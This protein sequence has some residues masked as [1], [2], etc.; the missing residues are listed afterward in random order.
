MK[1]LI[2][3][4]PKF[5]GYHLIE[6]ALTSGHQVTTFNRGQTSPE[7]FPEIEKLAG[8]R[9]GSLE[10]LHG[11][12]WDAVIDT[13]GYF[14]RLVGESAR[15][16]AE[17]VERYIFISTISVY[18]DAQAPGMDE[19][20]PLLK[21]ADERVEDISGANYGGLKALCEQAVEDALPGRSL[22]IRPGLIVG[23]RDPSDRYTYWPVRFARGGEILL[24]QGPEHAVQVIDVRDLAAWVIRMAEARQTGIYNATG[25]SITMGD[26]VAACQAATDSESTLTWVPEDFLADKKIG[27]WMELP[28][29]LPAE[30]YKEMQISIARALAAGLTFRPLAE[31]T[32]DTLAWAQSR[33]AD[34]EWRAGLAADK[35]TALLEQW[36]VLASQRLPTSK[37]R[38]RF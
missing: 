20:A 25:H 1:I 24:P 2:L 22:V 38:R 37:Y 7:L 12:K 16:L 5:L 15:L 36:Q 3:G 11:R 26:V 17:A 4:G 27:H 14:P 35:E 31:T 30:A 8:D 10:A 13:S 34:Y 32:A 28:L 23:P 18:E 33:P 21:L 29:Y 19:T 6:A 9:D